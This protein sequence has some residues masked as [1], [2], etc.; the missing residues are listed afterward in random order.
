MLRLQP[1]IFRL[2]TRAAVMD[3]EVLA[4]SLLSLER[5]LPASGIV[6]TVETDKDAHRRWWVFECLQT[7]LVLDVE[8]CL[9]HSMKTTI[10][11]Y[12]GTVLEVNTDGLLYHLIG[13]IPDQDGWSHE[14]TIKPLHY[15]RMGDHVRS[16]VYHLPTM[17]WECTDDT[18]GRDFKPVAKQLLEDNH[19]FHL[20]GRAGTGKGRSR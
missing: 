19:S 6:M 8:A 16:A 14:D 4:P 17:K 2:I 7:A 9:L 13:Q 11:R 20:R 1:Q 15:D 18:W 3:D 5:R 12:G 10:E